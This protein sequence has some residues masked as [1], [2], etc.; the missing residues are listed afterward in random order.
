MKKNLTVKTMVKELFF[1]ATSGRRTTDNFLDGTIVL[2]G[3]GYFYYRWWWEQK[4]QAV[5][6]GKE[7]PRAIMCGISRELR[8]RGLYNARAKEISKALDKVLFA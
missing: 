4:Y 1:A 8:L 6:D 5:M 2:E 3:L 7:T